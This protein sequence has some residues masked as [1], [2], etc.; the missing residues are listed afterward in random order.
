MLK[1][2][3]GPATEG[4]HSPWG[5]EGAKEFLLFDLGEIYYHRNGTNRSYVSRE[6]K[7]DTQSLCR[8]RTGWGGNRYDNSALLPLFHVLP[9]GDC[10]LNQRKGTGQSRSGDVVLGA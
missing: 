6:R 4:S 1:G 3:Q 9:V 5:S 7:R 10:G 8:K 2:T